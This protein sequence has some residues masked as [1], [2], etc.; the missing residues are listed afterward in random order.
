MIPGIRR[1]FVLQEEQYNAA[2]HLDEYN[3]YN[4]AAG[5]NQQIPEL[6]KNM[7]YLIGDT[8]KMYPIT[9]M[10]YGMGDSA[11][12]VLESGHHRYTYPVMTTLKKPFVI[13]R[14]PASLAPADLGQNHQ[15]AKLVFTDNRPKIRWIL[16]SQDGC[17]IQL[18]SEGVP[19]SDGFEYD[20]VLA[21]GSATA[22]I[23]AS[24]VMAG[25][26]WA[27]LAVYV[28][29]EESR[30]STITV[31]SPGKVHNQ[32][33]VMRLSMSWGDPR[34]LKRLLT[35][36]VKDNNG[37]E[38]KNWINWFYYQFEKEWMKMWENA[39]WY[40]R[41]NRDADS[42]KITLTDYL[43]GQV[44][45]TFAGILEQ[46]SNY[47]TYG[48]LT[49]D[50]LSGTISDVFYGMEDSSNMYIRAFTGM[51]GMEE[52]DRVLSERAISRVG[53]FS[54][55]AERFVTG[56][57]Y[58]MAIGGYFSKFYHINGHIV[59]FIHNPVFDTSE[60]ARITRRHPRT[61]RPMESY[62]IV[63]LDTEPVNGTPN[64]QRVATHTEN[65][66]HGV[67]R[68]LTDV[69]GTIGSI[70]SVSSPRP[71][72]IS[73][74]VNAGSYHRMAEGGIQLIRP[75]RCINLECSVR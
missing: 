46:I 18:Q 32:T 51:G 30:G 48:R 7:V 60:C 43:T 3:F 25:S 54:G 55:I 13:A 63:F 15:T 12:K 74:D 36:T 1:A 56:T 66:Q 37:G 8:E 42:G 2:S 50:L 58:D 27:P 23:P 20:V 4:S 49:Y 45:P 35:F 72:V 73:S 9:S 21:N 67:M 34:N 61:G 68:G 28:P 31:A 6:L 39:Y 17:Q 5:S 47:Q 29:R 22:S 57:G 26:L 40:S 19:V 14:T 41:F 71:P 70:D 65:Y 75:N 44:I 53:D 24:Q 38:S 11:K 10:L 52:V 16:Q 69:P 33:G 64:I 62:R 59:E